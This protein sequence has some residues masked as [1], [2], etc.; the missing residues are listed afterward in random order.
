MPVE[1][2]VDDPVTTD[3]KGKASI[4]NRGNTP[5]LAVPTETTH[6]LLCPF[7]G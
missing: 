2:L 4:D 6:N 7:D 1:M 5:S 3:P